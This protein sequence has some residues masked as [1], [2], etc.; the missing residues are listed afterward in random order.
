MPLG[1]VK[2]IQPTV[3]QFTVNQNQGAGT[4]DLCTASG[5]VLIKS[6]SFFQS[7]S[8]GGLTSMTIQTNNTTA[9]ILLASTLLA[10]LTGG[11]NLTALV[12]PTYLPSTK[13][14]QYTIVGAG[15]AGSLLA[16]IEYYPVSG[17]LV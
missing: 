15:N 4:Y 1:N 16:T 14:I 9:D 2:T 8:A 12:T 6:V 7:V 13:K 3:R 5:D 10:V 17:E 11:K